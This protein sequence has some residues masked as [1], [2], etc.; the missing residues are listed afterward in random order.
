MTHKYERQC[1]SC[2]SKDMEPD[3]RGVRCRSCGATWNEPPRSG[4]PDFN[5]VNDPH[6]PHYNP[7]KESYRRPSGTAKRR[8]SRARGETRK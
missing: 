1:W 8:A 6:G 4:P 7:R 3:G 5:I 2:G